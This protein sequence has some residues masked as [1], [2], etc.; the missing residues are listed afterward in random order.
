MRLGRNVSL[1]N[2]VRDPH[3]EKLLDQ[4]DVVHADGV[5]EG[6]R[7]VRGGAPALARLPVRPSNGGS[8]PQTD[9][10]AKLSPR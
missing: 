8:D 7:G 2:L 5:V 3:A 4:I 1:R 10:L 6:A 9:Q